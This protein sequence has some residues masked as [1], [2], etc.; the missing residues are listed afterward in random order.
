VKPGGPAVIESEALRVTVDPRV[1]GTITAVEHKSLGA[2]VLGRTPWEPVA[3]PMEPPAAP[4]E[5]TWLTRYG[6]GWPILFPNGGDAC[7]YAGVFHGFHGEAS[8]APWEAQADAASLLLTRRFI[9]VPAEMRRE[10]T[11]IG[12]VLTIRE[13]LHMLGGRPAKVMWGQHPTFGSD[14]LDGAFEIQSGACNVTIDNRYDPA[15]N[16]LIPGATGRWPLVPG[17]RGLFDLGEPV[18]SV[19]SL[20]YLHEFDS[21]WMSIRRLDGLVAVALSWD[22]TIFPCAWLWYELGGTDEP[23]WCGRTRLI[24]LEPNTTWPGTG[25]ADADRRGGRLLTLQ[26]GATITATVR[27]HVFKPEGAILGVD[28]SGRALSTPAP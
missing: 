10:L 16:P 19:A 24:G 23:P 25:L 4:D 14:L 8:V 7:E 27:L 17:K 26:P 15:T 28:A 3:A 13:T 18:G 9:S 12:D 20:A 11:V 5:R 1:G 6:G 22:D 2:S 21:P